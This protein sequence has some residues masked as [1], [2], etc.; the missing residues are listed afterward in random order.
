MSARFLYRL[1]I[2]WSVLVLIPCLSACRHE[3]PVPLTDESVVGAV[4]KRSSLEALPLALE[5]AEFSP[6]VP[7]LGIV[8]PFDPDE[9][10]SWRALALAFEKD[11]R[12]HRKAL[13]GKI[14]ISEGAGSSGPIALSSEHVQDGQARET[15]IALTIDLLGLFGA[16][17]SE[18]QRLLADE[19]MRTA[20]AALESAAWRSVFEVEAAHA[21]LVANLAKEA[22][23]KELLEEAESDAKRIPILEARGWLPPAMF[24]TARGMLHRLRTI[25]V[26]MRH[27]VES[28]RARLAGACGL[29]ASAPELALVTRDARTRWAPKVAEQRPPSEPDL[30]RARPDLRALKFEYAMKEAE[31][32]VAVAESRPDLRI[33]PKV[34]F[35][36]GELLT[37]GVLD[38]E[39]PSLS[40]ADAAIGAALI[41]RQASREALEDALANATNDVAWKHTKLMQDHQNFVEHGPKLD[42]ETRAA[43]R[44]GRARFQSD[45]EAL[46]SWAMDL[47][48]RWMAI[49]ESIDHGLHAVEASLLYREACGVPQGSHEGAP[50]VRR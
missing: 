24:N 45:P 8:Q 27:D 7:E 18:A 12:A 16:G 46:D 22:A 21:G 6:L 36:P 30:L 40:A 29:P 34:A 4:K 50:E 28:S 13:E 49:E 39:F 35:G 3:D 17:R 9:A 1:P 19:E 43:W 5:L 42:A 26:D 14:A 32:R 31:L 25:V 2:P 44:A 10:S 38:L 33:G 37:G 48:R 23:L 11:V 41:A 47:E 15:E 20:R